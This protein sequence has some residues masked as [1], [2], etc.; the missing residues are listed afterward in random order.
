ME[1]L[2]HLGRD[3]G[4]VDTARR[5]YRQALQV[6][7]EAGDRRGVVRLLEACAAAEAI[8]GAAESAL[9]L[10]GAADMLRQ[11]NGVP[12]LPADRVR[13]DALLESARRA[14]AATTWWMRGW[15]MSPAEAVAFALG[16]ASGN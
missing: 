9:T 3:R 5:W 15:S 12:L 1:R 8:G 13:F 2:G 7:D 10:A 14:S 11:A 16:N 6:L 4:D